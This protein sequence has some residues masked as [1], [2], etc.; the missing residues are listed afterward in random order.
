MRVYNFK[1]T[2]I[3]CIGDQL[4]TDILGANRAGLT[5]ILLNP[6]SNVDYFWTKINRYFEKKYIN[7]LQKEKF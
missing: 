6:M 4:F 3:A 1:D 7:I 5:S 2:E